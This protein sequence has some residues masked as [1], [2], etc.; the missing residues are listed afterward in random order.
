VNWG[1][2]R[3]GCAPFLFADVNYVQLS[4]AFL[5]EAALDGRTFEFA[6]GVGGD[7]MRSRGV[8]STDLA[9]GADGGSIESAISF[10]DVAERPVHGFFYEV[11]I[12]ARFALDYRKQADEFCVGRKFVLVGKIGD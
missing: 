8:E 3:V 2:R 1:A 12:V 7:P 11:A 4:R 6:K 5:G 9:R 10:A